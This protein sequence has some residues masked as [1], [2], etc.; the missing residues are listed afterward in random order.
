MS[1][2]FIKRVFQNIFKGKRSANYRIYLVS[3]A[4]AS[5]LW[6]LMKLSD[7]YTR[8]IE[9]PVEFVDLP[10][11]Y[12]IINS[13]DSVVRFNVSTDGVNLWNIILS[14]NDRLKVSLKKAKNIKKDDGYLHLCLASNELVG[15]ISRGLGVKIIGKIIHPDT[16][17]VDLDKLVTK[18]IPV[19]LQKV[20]S[21]EKGFRVY[22]Q[23]I[24]NPSEITITGP[25]SILENLTEVKTKILKKSNLKEAFNSDVKLVLPQK[26]SKLSH[27][28]VNVKVNVVQFIDANIEVNLQIKTNIPNLKLK[29]YPAKI[30]LDY[31]VAMTDYEKVKDTSFAVFVSVDSLKLLTDAPLIPY[32]AKKPIYVE[33]V[34]LGTEKVDYIIIK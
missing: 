26:C 7:N 28:K 31:Q 27:A 17:F 3:V 5:T 24:L 13:P 9:V 1:T 14:N 11:G 29:T 18:K 32:L 8:V 23:P 25:V 16:V 15:E 20:F 21:T 22:G 19:V 2:I 6:I 34:V 33:N 30:R 4:I 10:K 12:A